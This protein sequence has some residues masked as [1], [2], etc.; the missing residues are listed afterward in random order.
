[1]PRS[2]ESGDNDELERIERILRE[3]DTDALEGVDP[4]DEIWNGIEAAL[5]DQRRRSP[6]RAPTRD[7][8]PRLS[9][10]YRIDADDVVSVDGAWDTGQIPEL[11]V[12]VAGRMLWSHMAPGATKEIWQLI[13][14]RV[15]ASGEEV[16]IPL[17]CD[18]PSAR[19]WFDMRVIPLPERGVGFRSTLVFEESRPSMWLLDLHHDR[20]VAL[21]HVVMCAWCGLGLEG[22]TWME[23]E[24]LVARRRLLEA[25]QAPT[26]ESSV[27]GACRDEMTAELGAHSSAG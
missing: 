12:P 5:A 10:D 18:G 7:A 17:R 8:R 14:E 11:A 27:C 23:L 25:E 1:M 3:L 19:R 15:R 26:I 4:P 2:A 21:D 24:D 6:R 13:V 20:D 9:V 16:V 22:E